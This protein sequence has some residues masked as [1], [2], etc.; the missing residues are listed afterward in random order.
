M[1]KYRDVLKKKPIC[2]QCGRPVAKLV[3]TRVGSASGAKGGL[4]GVCKNCAGKRPWW[5]R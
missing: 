4:A 1:A 5:G 2:P 3:P